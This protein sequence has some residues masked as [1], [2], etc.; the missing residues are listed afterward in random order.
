M[1]C[2]IRT[3][4]PVFRPPFPGRTRG[5]DSESTAAPHHFR[6]AG[7]L[8]RL[9]PRWPKIAQY[10][11]DSGR[12]ILSKI[13]QDGQ[14]RSRADSADSVDPYGS[15]RRMITTFWRII[16]RPTKASFAFVRS[17]TWSDGCPI[18][19]LDLAALETG[20]FLS[21]CARMAIA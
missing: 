14:G 5:A 15:R 4:S 2:P 10:F 6:R 3:V 19:S 20:R 1:F 7:N 16:A 9:V 8:A 21:P 12:C 17:S 13:D 11:Q 18:S